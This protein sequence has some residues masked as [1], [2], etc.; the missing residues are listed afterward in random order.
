[1]V[2]DAENTSSMNTKIPG[3]RNGNCAVLQ[4]WRKMPF[5]LSFAGKM[6]YNN[7][8]YALVRRDYGKGD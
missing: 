7:M 1:M 5:P 2:K 8:C 4:R 6:Q 3:H